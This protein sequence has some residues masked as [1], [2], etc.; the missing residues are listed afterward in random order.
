MTK[1]YDYGYRFAVPGGHAACH[2]SVYEAVGGTVCI[3]TQQQD[4]FGGAAL[5]DGASALATLA[6]G[7]HHP[8]HDGRFVWVEHYAFERAPD[9]QGQAETFSFVTFQ[10]DAAGALNHPAWQVT[11]RATVEALVGQAVDA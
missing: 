10:R 11:N 9:P 7:W 3:A 6:E 1:T 8:V 4:K 2:V 5:T